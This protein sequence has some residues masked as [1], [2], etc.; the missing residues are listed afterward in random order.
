MHNAH[1][2][3][4]TSCLFEHLYVATQRWVHNICALSVLPYVAENSNIIASSMVI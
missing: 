2:Y 3:S 1:R 4:T